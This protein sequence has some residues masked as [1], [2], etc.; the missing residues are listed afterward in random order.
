[1]LSKA[2]VQGSNHP[3]QQKRQMNQQ[4]QHGDSMRRNNGEHSM[5][6]PKQQKTNAQT[7][8]QLERINDVI[9]SLSIR[10]HKDSITTIT[11]ECTTREAE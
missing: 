3:A 7:R 1:M 5:P 10:K 6:D 9:T 2:V 11:M 8:R 4:R